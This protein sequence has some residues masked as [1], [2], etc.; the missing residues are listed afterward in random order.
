MKSRKNISGLQMGVAVR[1]L[2]IAEGITNRWRTTGL[3]LFLEFLSSFL[4][5]GAKFSFFREDGK[6]DFSTGSLKLARRRSANISAFCLVIFIGFSLS[7]HA[8]EVS[9]FKIYFRISS[10]RKGKWQSQMFF[11][12]TSL[13]ESM[14]GWFLCF[15]TH[16]QTGLLI[17]LGKGSQFEYSAIKVTDN[18][19]K[20][21]FKKVYNFSSTIVTHNN[22]FFIY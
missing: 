9:N 13:I 19:R 3:Q 20:K 16:F 1:E 22:L 10:L 21:V 12:N 4:N 11:A 2:Q 14:M 5:I 8:L 15:T 6:L 7:R 17:L 18:V